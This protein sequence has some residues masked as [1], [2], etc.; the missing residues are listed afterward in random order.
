MKK[1]LPLTLIL[2]GAAL[3]I[4]AVVFWI[5]S[6]TSTEP[7]SFGKTLLDWVTLIAGLGASFKGWMDL[8]KPDKPTPPTANIEVKGGKPQ[9]STGDHARNIQTETYIENQTI[10]QPP[11]PKTPKSL[12]QLPAPPLDFIGREKELAQLRQN[13]EKGV[14]ISGVQGMG[15]IGKTALGL[16]LAEQIAPKYPDG[17][18]YLDLRGAHEQMPLT[19]EEVMV[20]VIKSFHPEAALPIDFGELGGLYR[21]IINGKRVLLF[22]D[23]A[24]DEN[25]LRPLLPPKSCMLFVTSRQHFTLPGL[26]TINLETLNPHDARDLVQE[27]AVNVTDKD[28]DTLSKQCGYLP[29]AIRVSVSVLSLR[30]DWSSSELIERLRDNRARLGLV[31]S[32]LHLSY[33][34]L[35][36]DLQRHMLQLGVFAAPFDKDAAHAIWDNDSTEVTDETLGKLLKT[37]LLNYDKSTSEYHFHDL[38]LL[39]LEEKCRQ[40]IQADEILWRYAHHYLKIA[41]QAENEYLRGKDSVIPALSR[42]RRV[43]IHLDTVSERLAQNGKNSEWKKPLKAENWLVEST[44]RI[45]EILG[46]SVSSKETLPFVERGLQASKINNNRASEAWH[47][48]YLAG[49]YNNIGDLQKSIECSEMSLNIYR[50]IGETKASYSPL[51]NLGAAYAYLGDARR[52]IEYFDQALSIVRD[53][54]GNRNEGSLLCNIGVTYLNLGETKLAIEFLERALVIIHDIGNLRVEGGIL[55][56]LGICYTTLGDMRRAIDYSKQ[57]LTIA[58]KIGDKQ[59]EGKSLSNLGGNYHSLGDAQQAAEYYEQALEIAREINDKYSESTILGNL[60]GAYKSLGKAFEAIKYYE[61]AL[62]AVRDIGDKHGEGIILGNLGFLKTGDKKFYS[63]DNIQ[64]ALHLTQEIGDKRT[65]AYMLSATA[66]VKR[67]QGELQESIALYEKALQLSDEIGDV[68]AKCQVLDNMANA[69]ADLGNQE[70]AIE[71][72]LNAMELSTDEELT[73]N[74]AWNLATV[75]NEQEQY[76]LAAKYMQITVGFEQKINHPNAVA[77]LES[78]NKVRAKMQ[79]TTKPEDKN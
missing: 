21:S 24:R 76:E 73:A 37:S 54:G 33:E 52:A 61:Q 53:E 56:N 36:N 45:A 51:S 23:N 28:A 59:S 3:L 66:S 10:Q 11:E 79:D 26:D 4:T 65:E 8:F 42:F 72:Y 7:Q 22:F 43:W 48:N 39:F 62:L 75:Y 6:S 60:G 77:D 14:L 47:L 74:I 12:N 49:S 58:Q 27:I 13:I 63:S 40:D 50:D 64:D 30:P 35:D 1:A 20:H 18:I 57:A 2:I 32:S 69:Y 67:E 70:K 71:Y 38:T 19:P 29:L 9:I 41:S 17:Q 34:S 44:N 16:K 55:D 31:E 78:L 25:Q 68:Y 46:V 15:G 5:D